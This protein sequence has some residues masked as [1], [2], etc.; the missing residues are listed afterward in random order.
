MSKL[1]FKYGQTRTIRGFG[2]STIHRPVLDESGREIGVV[3]TRTGVRSREPALTSHHATRR[4]VQGA[5]IPWL[6]REEDSITAE[7]IIR[8]A[9][10]K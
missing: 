1:R 2:Y 10:K 9:R 8:G 5:N 3:Q 4:S 7:E 6:E